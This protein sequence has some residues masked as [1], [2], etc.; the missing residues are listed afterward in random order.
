[1]VTRSR[2]STSAFTTFVWP[3]LAHSARISATVAS[4]ATMD[5]RPSRHVTWTSADAAEATASDRT[6][7]SASASMVRMALPLELLGLDV[8][9]ARG[10]RG[11]VLHLHDPR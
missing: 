6:T 7:E 8:H 10:K 11:V 1:M 5:T 9:E 4:F 2:E 3:T